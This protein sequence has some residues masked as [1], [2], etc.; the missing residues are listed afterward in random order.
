MENSMASA[1]DLQTLFQQAQARMKQQD[2]LCDSL[3]VLLRGQPEAAKK[4]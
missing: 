4:F 3:R 2:N 1:L